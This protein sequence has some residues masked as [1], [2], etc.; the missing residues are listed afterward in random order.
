MITGEIVELKPITKED[1]DYILKWRNSDRVRKNFIYQEPFTKEG[2]ERW[3][4][5]MIETGKA[6]Q[7]IIYDKSSQQPVGSVYLRDIDPVNEKA[8]YGI[9][10][11]ETSA[12]GRGLGSEAAR[13]TVQ[14]GFEQLGLHKIFLRV[15][16]DN[17]G[18]IR[19][20]EK[21]GFIKEGHFKADVKIDN[22]Y[23]D[24]VFMA[25]IKHTGEVK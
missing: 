20:Y 4:E 19:S 12:A 24:M 6:A 2:H 15:F 13:L 21:A 22:I 11:G 16:A 17:V 14:Y 5:T 23:R 3:L 18:A 25:M 1:T 8:E 10:I 7:F 9:F